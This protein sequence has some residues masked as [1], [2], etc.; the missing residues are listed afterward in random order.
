MVMWKYFILFFFQ[1]KTHNF[2]MAE[3]PRETELMMKTINFTL[4]GRYQT[5]R[6]VGDR[7]SC[8][9]IGFA[10]RSIKKMSC[11]WTQ[12][13]SL[14]CSLSSYCCLST[15]FFYIYKLLPLL[16]PHLHLCLSSGDKYG[17]VIHLY[18]RDCSI[19]RRH[20]KVMPSFSSLF[21]FKILF[22][23]LLH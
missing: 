9:K 16:F 12:P 2:N 17:N 10:S 7:L 13:H 5:T 18:E 23:A 4:V 22:A 3:R 19:Q 11:P 20:Q 8:S 1:N 14:H 15:F 6:W 21:S